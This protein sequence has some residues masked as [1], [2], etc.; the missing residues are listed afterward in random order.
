MFNKR[1]PLCTIRNEK[2]VKCA[3]DGSESRVQRRLMAN[4]LITGTP[5][6]ERRVVTRW[7]TLSTNVDECNYVDANFLAAKLVP[8]MRR[9]E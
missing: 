6:T 3:L 9:R 1:M 5:Y 7:W 8:K 2:T 4:S